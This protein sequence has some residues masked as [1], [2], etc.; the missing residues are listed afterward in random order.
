LTASQPATDS[1]W[2]GRRRGKKLRPGRQALV[3]DLLPSLRIDPAA[4]A[5]QDLSTLFPE[6]VDDL[7]LEIGFGA[8]EHLPAASIGRIFIL[9]NDPWPKKRHHRR[10]FVSPQTVECL[11]RLLK[12]DGEILF[13]SDHMGYIAWALEHFL[14]GGALRWLAGRPSDWRRPPDGWVATRYEK[15]ARKRGANPVFLRFARL[16]RSP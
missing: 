1:R 5:G 8:G 15:K 6:P 2:Y 13:A 11:A 3:D 4:L 10:R 14:R 9:F 7:W 12:D 16:P